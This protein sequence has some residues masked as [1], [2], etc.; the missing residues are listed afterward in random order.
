[1]VCDV[2]EG[3]GSWEVSPRVDVLDYMWGSSVGGTG[4]KLDQLKLKWS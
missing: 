1:M 4:D 2:S 3:A